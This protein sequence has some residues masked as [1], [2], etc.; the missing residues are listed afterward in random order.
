MNRPSDH[1]SVQRLKA[2]FEIASKGWDDS[3]AI[4]TINEFEIVVRFH[5]AVHTNHYA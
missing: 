1:E 4:H 5:R 2:W 3:A